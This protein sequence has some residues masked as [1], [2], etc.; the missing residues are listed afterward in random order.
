M[1][2]ARNTTFLVIIVMIYF[3]GIIVRSENNTQCHYRFEP[4]YVVPEEIASKLNITL[5]RKPWFS[6]VL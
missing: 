1:K 4:Y 2:Q 6:I 5:T 3:I